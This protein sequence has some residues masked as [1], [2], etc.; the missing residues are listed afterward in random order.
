MFEGHTAK[1]NRAFCD[2]VSKSTTSSTSCFLQ[3]SSDASH[4]LITHSSPS[5]RITGRNFLLLSPRDYHEESTHKAVMLPSHV[6]NHWRGVA[7]STPILWTNIILRVTDETFESR[8]ALVT[9]WFSR[10]GGSPLSFTLEGCQN[11]QPILAFLLQ[12]CN[13]WQYII[14]RVPFETL[15]CFDSAKG[16]LQLL[17]TVR[18]D[19]VRGNTSYSIGDVFESAPK[20]RKISLNCRLICNNLSGSW[21]HLTELDAVHVYTVTDCIAML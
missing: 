8:A 1:Q 6:C 7:S 10:S 16:H 3:S 12:Y 4:F 20:L 11:I 14:L 19:S 15:R 13:R 5:T 9:T 18:I 2:Q 21:I 17:A